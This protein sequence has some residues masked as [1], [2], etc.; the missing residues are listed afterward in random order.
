MAVL[1]RATQGNSELCPKPQP[2]MCP[3]PLSPPPSPHAHTHLLH[4]CSAQPGSLQRLLQQ[5]WQVSDEV[6]SDQGS[7]RRQCRGRTSCL[8]NFRDGCQLRCICQTGQGTDGLLPVLQQLRQECL[9]ANTCTWFCNGTA[10]LIRLPWLSGAWSLLQHAHGLEH[11]LL[12][13][14]HVVPA[15]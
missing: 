10:T 13:L 7:Q 6:C 15:V 3:S 11:S 9:W 14:M 1:K 4:S 2:H 12:L 8:S 5:G